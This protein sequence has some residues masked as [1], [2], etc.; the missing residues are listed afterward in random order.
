MMM[1]NI[2]YVSCKIS[3]IC[4]LHDD[5]FIRQSIDSNELFWLCGTHL[6]ASKNF[7]TIYSKQEPINDQQRAGIVQLKNFRQLVN[8]N[9]VGLAN[10][11]KRS[12]FYSLSN[13]QISLL[14][15]DRESGFQTVHDWFN[16]DISDHKTTAII[17]NNQSELISCGLDGRLMFF[18][19]HSRITSKSRPLTLNS[20]H[21][22]DKISDNEFICGTTSGHL[23]I[24]DRRNENVELNMA[25]EMSI[26][27]AVKRN[28]NNPHIVAC[29]NDLGLL[30]IWDL[31]N[32]GHRPMQPISVHGA[33]IN[34]LKY[35]PN[36]RN[37]IMTSSL[38]GQLI[39][40]N[41]SNDFEIDTVEA[42]I[43]NKKNTYPINCFDIY[44]NQIVFADDNEVLYLT[45][46]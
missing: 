3:A 38:D 15:Y 26:I 10:Y 21:C 6:S 7:L 2:E 34:C 32:S 36:E 31:R 20:L 40:W 8:A 43:D 23:K 37:T 27:T 35:I 30:Y 13:G 19:I 12:S 33:E 5:Q 18:D 14:Q 1:M 17:V 46:F 28:I 29:G 4:W 39:K 22:M 42:I 11:D 45:S 25:N 44:K 24:F 16:D 41:I 9:V